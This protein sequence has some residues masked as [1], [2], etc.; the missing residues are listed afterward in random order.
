VHV[1]VQ[2]R[3]SLGPRLRIHLAQADRL[4]HRSDVKAG[5]LRFAEYF[6]DVL[7]ETLLLLLEPLDA[8]DEA[9]QLLLGVV[10]NDE[11]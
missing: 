5:R 10:A 4:A 7:G 6:L 2:Q 1:C 9:D 3:F 8:L 11:V